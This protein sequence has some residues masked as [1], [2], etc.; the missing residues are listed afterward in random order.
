MESGAHQKI[1]LHPAC[2]R[3]WLVLLFVLTS[4]SM[5]AQAR[6][7]RTMDFNWKFKTGDHPG[8]EKPEFNDAAW[9][10]LNVPHDWSIE[11]DFS[12][13]IEG[14]FHIGYL[15]TGIGWYRKNFSLSAN[16]LRNTL[17]IEFDGVYMNSDVWINGKHLGHY[18]NGYFSF[19]YELNKYAKAG[20]NTIVVRVD[21]SLQPNSRWYSGSG[22][23]RHVNLVLVNPLHI[24]H[25]GINLTTPEISRESATVMVKTMVENHHS[26]IRN[27]SVVSVITDREGRKVAEL[28][29]PFTLDPG[30]EKETMQTLKV[31]APVIWSHEN[32]ALYTLKSTLVENGK[33]LDNLETRFGIRKTEFLADRGFLL[34]GEQVKLKGVC[35]HH[36]AG[37]VGAAVPEG[38]WIRY[39][40]LL[41][42]MGCNAI[43]T[44][45]NPVAPEFLDM[46]DSLGFL[47]MDESF[48][49]LQEPDKGGRTQGYHLYFK[50]WAIHDLTQ[51]IHR[52]RNHPSV[53]MWSVANE[54]REQVTPDGHLTV[55]K[56]VELCHREDPTRPVTAACNLIGR[57]PGPSTTVEFMEELDIIG[58]NYANQTIRRRELCFNI[59]KL[60]HP[61]WKMTGSENSSVY[62]IRGEYSLGNDPGKVN[63]SYNT[64][65]IDPGMLWKNVLTHDYVMGDFMW[66]GIDYLGEA[67]WPNIN[68][69]CGVIDR[70]GFPKDA[71]YF[72]KSLWTKEPMLHILPHW[73]WPGREGQILPVLVYTNCD[74]VELFLNGK[75][76][77]EKRLQF[78]RR[79]KTIVGNWST[80]DAKEHLTT[81]DL[82]LSWDLPY[83]PGIIRAVGRNKG[84]VVQTIEM[85]TA[86][87]AAAIRLSTDK[88]RIAPDNRDVAHIT[89]E[90]VDREGNIVP[91][92]DHLVEFAVEGG[93]TLIG[94]DNGNPQDH[95][96]FKK[97][98]RRAFHGLCLAIL[99]SNGKSDPIKVTA[100]SEKLGEFHL[101]IMCDTK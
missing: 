59:D 14:G 37:G 47:V 86:G 64:V 27:G 100:R 29:T 60:A 20:R 26:G 55:R 73:N 84:E 32:P 46:C 25:Y 19:R 11:S 40:K 51:M 45:H 62:S 97:N 31:P 18:P 42:D 48:D 44:S 7:V 4:V 92:A 36:T 8:A 74:A 61:D 10:T 90:I 93:A 1:H 35:L 9:R 70:S 5:N 3:Y 30:I 91:D 99:Q 68:P 39:L 89:V 17:W 69:P 21:N 49:V 87:E 94:V 33:I 2:K 28:E 78:P 63:A 6:Q 23:Y 65:M 38:V 79:G 43:R 66:T 101:E 34:N 56:L 41:K 81:S 67:R 76:Y 24:G 71:F 22:I 50:D 88:N 58:Y 98:N 54:V 96:S 13:N 12:E 72:Y 75:S 57:E 77:G 85:K 80:Y 53:I 52:D 82:H 95:N 83:E 16:D 15:P